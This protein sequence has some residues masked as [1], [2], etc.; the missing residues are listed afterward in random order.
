[1]TPNHF[2]TSSLFCKK[3]HAPH[4]PLCPGGRGI[5]RGELVIIVSF[6][7]DRERSQDESF[8][9]GA[10]EVAEIKLLVRFHIH[11]DGRD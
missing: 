8:G 4:P 2:T 11:S 7:T 5:R 10:E 9:L 3:G 1:M 6:L